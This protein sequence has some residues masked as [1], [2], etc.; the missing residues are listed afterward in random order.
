M[1]GDDKKIIAIDFC[2]PNLGICEV[3]LRREKFLRSDLYF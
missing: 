3:T 2:F 1:G